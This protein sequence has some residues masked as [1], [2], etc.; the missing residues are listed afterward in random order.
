MSMVFI[1]K[2]NPK[3]RCLIGTG[4]INIIRM[5]VDNMEEAVELLTA[6]GFR[7]AQQFNGPSGLSWLTMA[8]SA[9]KT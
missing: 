8:G 1:R 2:K 3:E 5:N 7:R 9:C 4:H 6:H